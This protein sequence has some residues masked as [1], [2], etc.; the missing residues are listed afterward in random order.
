M[1]K[2]RGFTLVELLVVLVIAGILAAY[3]V[4]GIRRMIRS[5]AMSD[6]VNTF[7]ADTRYAR[8]EAIR[9]GGGVV[10]CRSNA[11]EAA[12]PVCNTGS[13]PA[14]TGWVTGW[15]IFH[16]LDGDGDKDTNEPLLRVQGPIT[17]VNSAVESNASLKLRFVGTG[18]LRDLTSGAGTFQF[19]SSPDFSNTDQR[20]VCI[21]RGGRAR[22]AGDGYAGCP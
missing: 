1:R 21:S 9:R 8:S 20:V 7:L 12:S 13:G 18:R 2:V 4:P 11:P 10:M 6:A 16:D 15:L 5:A 14:V 17:S 22:I 19:G 3:A